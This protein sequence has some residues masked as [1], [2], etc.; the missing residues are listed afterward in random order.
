MIPL[1]EVYLNFG[2]IFC[3]DSL[4]AQRFQ[5]VIVLMFEGFFNLKLKL[6]AF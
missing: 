6:L 5:T 3:R 2:E 4:R 1:N